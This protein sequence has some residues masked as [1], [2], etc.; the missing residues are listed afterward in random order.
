MPYSYT[1]E[2]RIVHVAWSGTINKED[3]DSFGEAMPQ[4]GQGLGFAPD[5][6]HTFYETTGFSFQPIAAYL[7]SLQSSHVQIPNPIRAAIVTDT[8]EGEALATVFKTL[9]HT[10]N[11]EMKVFANEAAARHWLSLK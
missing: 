5:V 6:I 2:G 3:L 9:N 4:I 11:L 10:T 1:L 8:Q 7:Y